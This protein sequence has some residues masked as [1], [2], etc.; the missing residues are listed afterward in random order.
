MNARKLNHYMFIEL[1][2]N[3]NEYLVDADHSD[4]ERRDYLNRLVH[5]ANPSLPEA[6]NLDRLTRWFSIPFELLAKA[7]NL[8]SA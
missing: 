4:L 6:L 5:T 2:Q 8:F 3:F 7:N 1:Y